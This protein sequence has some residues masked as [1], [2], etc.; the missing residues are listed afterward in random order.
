MR[1]IDHDIIRVFID[2]FRACLGHYTFGSTG[3]ILCTYLQ[4]I[5]KRVNNPPL[6]AWVR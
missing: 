4:R 1:F 6:A 3:I 5:I 2:I